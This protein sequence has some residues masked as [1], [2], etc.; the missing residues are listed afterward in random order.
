M[1]VMDRILKEQAI[2][3][4]VPHGDAWL[5]EEGSR[6]LVLIAGG[7]GFLRALNLVDRVGAAARSRHFDLLGRA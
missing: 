1:A 2:T 4:D 6:P 5:R 3:V 7:T